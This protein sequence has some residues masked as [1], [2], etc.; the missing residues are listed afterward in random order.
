[1]SYEADTA[2][3]YRAH[4][5]E[6]RSIAESDRLEETRRMLIGVALSYESLAANLEALDAIHSR[7]KRGDGTARM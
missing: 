7:G 2:I 3:R 6:L 4:A 1:M 5:E